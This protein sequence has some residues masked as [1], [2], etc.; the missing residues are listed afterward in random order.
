MSNDEWSPGIIYLRV[1]PAPGK[2]AYVA[3]HTCW[4]RELFIEAENDRRRKE[5][6]KI[7]VLT[8]QQ[9][10]KERGV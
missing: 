4:N 9:Y 5:G 3:M 7:E 1:T 8:E 10:N 6:G 2:R